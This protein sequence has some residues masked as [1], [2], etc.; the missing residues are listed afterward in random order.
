MEE[1]TQKPL[2][3]NNIL[4]ELTKSSPIQNQRVSSSRSTNVNI[5]VPTPI[6]APTPGII[7]TPRP[8]SSSE[9]KLPELGKKLDRSPVSTPPS[10]FKSEP[11]ELTLSIRTMSA[12]LAKLRHG[13]KPVELEVKKVLSPAIQD[14]NKQPISSQMSAKPSVSSRI[15][16][17]PSLGTAQSSQQSVLSKDKEPGHDHPERIISKNKDELPSFLGAL[18]PKR[19]V[20]QPG[21]EKVEYGLIAKVIGSGMTTGIVSTV[22]VALVIYGFF[23]FFVLRPQEIE[24]QIPIPT[25]TPRTI[26]TPEVNELE[27]IFKNISVVDFQLSEDKTETVSGLKFLIENQ[28]LARKEIKRLNFTSK[29]VQSFKFIDALNN[30]LINYPLTLKDVIKDNNLIFLYG[31]GELVKDLAFTNRLIFIVE[32][33]NIRGALEIM[34]TWEGTISDDISGIFGLDLDKEASLDFLDNEHQG[35][36][37]R[38]K[39]FPFPDKSIDYAIVSSL[40][41]RHYLVIA[42]SR[43]SMYYPADKI[44]GL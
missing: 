23:Y 32:V 29:T 4:D 25:Q 21:E 11:S 2:T 28:D 36:K 14:N 31:Q 44:R 13:Q 24:S 18:I 39:N 27:A 12:D 22:I 26:I 38:Y 8:A 33:T 42:N 30:L 43:E 35:V 1:K 41:G 20:L 7:S 17:P 6:P 10:M 3:I 19:P 37:I 9:V 16:S 15:I 40:S 34:K 5:L